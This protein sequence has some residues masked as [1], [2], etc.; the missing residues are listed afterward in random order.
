MLEIM[1]CC[2]WLIALCWSL[3]CLNVADWGQ[4]S[5]VPKFILCIHRPCLDA[6]PL[7]LHLFETSLSSSAA[8]QEHKPVGRPAW[9]ALAGSNLNV[10][11]LPSKWSC[12][13]KLK[14]NGDDLTS[15][16]VAQKAP[17]QVMKSC[18]WRKTVSTC[19]QQLHLSIAC[20]TAVHF[21]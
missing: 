2:I 11:P 1:L 17:L 21:V 16:S 5:I 4:H 8:C 20:I 15:R 14:W 7:R 13:P 9:H 19:T 12:R 10:I 18:V 6:C 3:S